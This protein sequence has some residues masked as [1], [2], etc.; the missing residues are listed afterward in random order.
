MPGASCFASVSD[1]KP[2][3]A[4]QNFPSHK[5]G[6]EHSVQ[7]RVFFV[8]GPSGLLDCFIQKES[9]TEEHVI[10]VQHN[11]VC[12]LLSGFCRFVPVRMC[13]SS[14]PGPR[15]AVNLGASNWAC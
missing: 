10:R 1:L 11:K 3:K 7:G 14:L 12:I 5:R 2:D 8:S 4:A 9:A 6:P 15:V 13:V